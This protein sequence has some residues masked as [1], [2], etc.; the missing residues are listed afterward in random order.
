MAKH[1]GAKTRAGGRCKAPA[2]ANGRCRV[3]GGSS[4]GAPKGTRNALKYGIYTDFMTPD[5]RRLSAQMK[6]GHLNDELRL[7]RIRLRRALAAEQAAQGEPELQEVTQ[8][9]GGGE[10]V[11]IETRKR[12]VRDYN[13]IIDKLT[14]RVESLEKTRK[15]LADDAGGDGETVSGFEVVQYDD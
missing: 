11:P 5:E 12:V 3:H 15:L 2:M 4:T 8:N 7:T 10:G 1:C 14:A 6:L 9:D 13:A